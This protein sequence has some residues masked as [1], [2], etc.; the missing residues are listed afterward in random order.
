MKPIVEEFTYREM[1]PEDMNRF[2]REAEAM[3][4]EAMRKVFA[5]M[6]RGLA[7]AMVRFGRAFRAVAANP[8][9]HTS[10]GTR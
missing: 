4:A 8:G 3:R 1:S 10:P 6:Y 2:L 7:H 9:I 5:D